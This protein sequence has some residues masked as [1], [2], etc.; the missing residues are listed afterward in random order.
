MPMLKM[1]LKVVGTLCGER[2]QAFIPLIWCRPHRQKRT[3]NYAATNG[4]FIN[5]AAPDTFRCL[6]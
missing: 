2:P 3:I 1:L 6:Y 5:Q 4:I